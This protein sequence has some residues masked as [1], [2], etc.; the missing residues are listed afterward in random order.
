MSPM[1]LSQGTLIRRSTVV[2]NT[3]LQKRNNQNSVTLCILNP[4]LHQFSNSRKAYFPLA[5]QICIDR[6]ANIYLCPSS[7]GPEFTV[8]RGDVF[9][10]PPSV[11]FNTYG[12]GPYLRG[13]VLLQEHLAQGPHKVRGGSRQTF[14][15]HGATITSI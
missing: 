14:H 8:N 3:S 4:I 7:G 13:F 1:T 9:K 2:K 12:N 15:I 10:P 11:P 5:P 6:R